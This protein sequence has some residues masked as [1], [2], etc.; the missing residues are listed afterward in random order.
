VVQGRRRRAGSP[1]AHGAGTAARGAGA[2]ACGARAAA[3]AEHGAWRRRCL[4]AVAH[5]FGE[6]GKKENKK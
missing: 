5:G 6:E 4:S 3:R 1:A 2:A